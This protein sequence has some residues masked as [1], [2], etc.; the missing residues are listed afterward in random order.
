M[1][2][3]GRDAEGAEGVRDALGGAFWSWTMNFIG[4]PAGNVPARIADLTTGPQPVGVQLI[5]R[6]WREDLI[7]EA[8]V[9]IEDRIGPMAPH[10]WQRMG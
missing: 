1:F 2:T 5:G 7:V 6:R 9:A 8:M 10:L 3:A 4:L